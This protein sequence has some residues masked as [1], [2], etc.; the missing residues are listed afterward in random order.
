MEY[1][2]LIQNDL[3]C[4]QNLHISKIFCTFA[5]I[6]ENVSD[7]GYRDNRYSKKVNLF[8]ITDNQFRIR[9]KNIR[10]LISTS[11]N[12]VNLFQK[13]SYTFFFILANSQPIS[14]RSCRYTP[15]FSTGILGTTIAKIILQNLLLKRFG[16]TVFRS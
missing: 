8:S 11:S 14:Q 5:P 15:A 2:I 12:S 13:Q 4:V 6:F 10:L 1:T 3:S 9:V 7:L 16:I